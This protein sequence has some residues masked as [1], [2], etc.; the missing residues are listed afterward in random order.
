MLTLGLEE[1]TA[2]LVSLGEEEPL[3]AGL[4]RRRLILDSPRVLARDDREGAPERPPEA[5]QRTR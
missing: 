4:R 3:I 2:V 1:G 5:A